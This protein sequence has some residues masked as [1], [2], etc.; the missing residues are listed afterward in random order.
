MK[1]IFSRENMITF[2]LVTVAC[3]IAVVF[4][5]PLA[6]SLKAKFT[7]TTPAGTGGA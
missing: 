2:V 4:G 5:A 1:K 6:A 3:S 7:P